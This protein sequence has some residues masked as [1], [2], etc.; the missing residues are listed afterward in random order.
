MAEVTLNN[1]RMLDE[2]ESAIL[3]ALVYEYILTGK[4]VGSR[5]FVQKYSF[6]ISP[7]TM[8]NVMS[9]LEMLGYLKQPHT[10]AGRIPTDRG[11]R[12]YV[13]SLL[14][15]YNFSYNDEIRIKEEMITRELQLDKIFDSITK[16]LS[17]TSRYAGVMLTP[18]TD[19]AVVKRIELIPVDTNEIL[20]IL[21][22]RTGMVITKKVVVSANLTP[23]SLL[24]YS[25]YLTSELCGYS[26]HE[27]KMTIF[28]RLRLEKLTGLNK[29]MA[30]D[31]AELGLIGENESEL[32]ID[33]IENLLKI[34]EM[35]EEERLNSLLNI[36]EEKNILRGILEITMEMDGI[37]TMI[38]EEIDDSRVTG[39]SVVATP[40]K[41]GNRNV[42][43]IGVLG[44]TRMD[45]EKVV[46]LV[47]YTGKVVSDLLTR[48]SK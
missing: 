21:V 15:K 40:Y 28:E 38:G 27:I 30:L 4:P 35:V 19:F 48:M 41:I 16:L 10:S 25:R 43:V 5:S 11:Y 44:P 37:R 9:D 29:E 23:D 33:G 12:F 18:R 14:E 8:R 34:P 24:E 7:A 13:D 36:I 3:R 39:C 17:N 26:L 22:A 45:Y 31:I 20:M 32:H 42:G 2:R 46:P 47:D 1:D 6:S